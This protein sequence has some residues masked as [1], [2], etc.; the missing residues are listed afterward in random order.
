MKIASGDHRRTVAAIAGRLGLDGSAPE[1]GGELTA[2]DDKALTERAEAT[3]VFGRVE[4]A[5]KARLIRALRRSGHYVAM[6]G[7]GVNDI[8]ALR[9][10]NLGLAMQSGSP[11]ARAACDVVLLGDSFS[12]LP[13]AVIAGQRIVEGMRLVTCLL[14]SRTVFAVLVVLGALALSLE[15][16]FTPRTNAILAL[17]TVGIPTLVLAAWAPVGRPRAALI[18]SALRFSIPAGLGMAALALAVYWAYATGRRDIMEARSALTT[19]G[20]FCGILLIPFV[21]LTGPVRSWALALALIAVYGAI[22]LVPELRGLF[23]LTALPV[24]ELLALAA[25]AVTWA[26][27][28]YWMRAV[29]AVPRILRAG[30]RVVPR[31]TA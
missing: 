2:L 10:A 30:K 6:I 8:I 14:L 27:V 15:F 25:L 1:D 5:L 21:T 12:V 19:V 17:L 16:P 29:R 4:P 18:P 3:T 26:V 13:R 24:A 9:E 28:V 20:I 31:R 23:E 11:A 22:L 7:D